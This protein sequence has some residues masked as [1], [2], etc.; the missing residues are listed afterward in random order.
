MK[1]KAG[2]CIFWAKITMKTDTPITYI[3]IELFPTIVWSRSR[4]SAHPL[5]CCFAL[6]REGERNG[7]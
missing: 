1:S 7:S 4:L 2:A 6:E 3:Q 5:S